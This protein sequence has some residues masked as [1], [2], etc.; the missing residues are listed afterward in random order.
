MTID[1]IKS[2]KPNFFLQAPGLQ[3]INPPKMVGK[4]PYEENEGN[5][6]FGNNPFKNNT[7]Y[8]GLANNNPNLSGVSS[9]IFG[10]QNISNTIGIA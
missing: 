1:S 7:Q 2:T 5:P 3:A 8:V 4:Q 9:N 6:A 10:K